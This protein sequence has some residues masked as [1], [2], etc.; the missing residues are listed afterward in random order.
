MQ[1]HLVAGFGVSAVGRG[2]PAVPW[3]T[4]ALTSAGSIQS[5]HYIGVGVGS[6]AGA[7]TFVNL[8]TCPLQ[9][10]RP[11]WLTKHTW[12]ILVTNQGFFFLIRS[13]TSVLLYMRQDT[14]VISLTWVIHHNSCYNA[15]IIWLIICVITQTVVR[16]LVIMS[17]QCAW[18]CV[19]YCAIL[20][21]CT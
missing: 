6:K 4:L 3:H 21:Y 8:N 12:D 17:P 2:S 7:W 15:L 10:L 5:W 11:K 14:G 18:Y 20:W 13:L 9:D 16:Y 19:W 1:Q